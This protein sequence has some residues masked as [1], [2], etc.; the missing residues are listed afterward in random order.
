MQ[1]T[2][3]LLFSQ[4]ACV[5]R[6]SCVGHMCAIMRAYELRTNG[7]GVRCRTARTCYAQFAQTLQ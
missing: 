6:S 3:M 4:N 7:H 2:K 1:L 5:S